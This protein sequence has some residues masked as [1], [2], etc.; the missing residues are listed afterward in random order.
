MFLRHHFPIVVLLTIISFSIVVT[1][2]C[3]RPSTLPDRNDFLMGLETGRH[4]QVS[5]YQFS[6]G[7]LAIALSYFS[8]FSFLELYFFISSLS[9]VRIQLSGVSKTID[10]I[11]CTYS[12]IHQYL[13]GYLIQLKSIF[14]EKEIFHVICVLKMEI[15]YPHCPFLFQKLLTNYHTGK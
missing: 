3:H 11:M 8:L 9:G 5:V 2:E 6:Q 1:G 4:D 13:L 12:L 10:N 14:Q 15:S 7:S